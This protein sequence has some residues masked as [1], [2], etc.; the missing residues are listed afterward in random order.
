VLVVADKVDSNFKRDVWGIG[1][2]VSLDLDVIFNLHI[3]S[4]AHWEGLAAQ[5]RTIWRAVEREGVELM[6]EPVPA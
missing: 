2:E 6:S 4:R 3:Y 1:A 5:R